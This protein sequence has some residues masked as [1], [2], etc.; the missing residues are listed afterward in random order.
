MCQGRP[1]RSGNSLRG[2]VAFGD[3]GLLF[4]LCREGRAASLRRLSARFSLVLQRLGYGGHR[5][6][7][8]LRAALLPE[9]PDR[10]DQEALEGAERLPAR[11]AARYSALQISPRLR[12]VP[13]LGDRDPMQD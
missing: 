11:F 3:A 6:D 12:T 7:G 5:H 8:W 2:V 13:G 1:L 4:W 9:P 10:A